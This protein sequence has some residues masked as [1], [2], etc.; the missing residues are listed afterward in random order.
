MNTWL[1]RD[2]CYEED[3]VGYKYYEAFALNDAFNINNEADIT[4]RNKINSE[5]ENDRL[6][7]DGRADSAE[8]ISLGFSFSKTKSSYDY[9]QN[10]HKRIGLAI[11]ELNNVP[12]WGGEIKYK[13]YDWSSVDY[14]KLSPE[15]L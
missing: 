2:Y 3:S 12:A 15:S 4:L 7:I 8:T 5:H 9:V 6:Q 13:S 11:E 10:N 14:S 1:V